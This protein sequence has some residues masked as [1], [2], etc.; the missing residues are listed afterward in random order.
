VTIRLHA[1]QIILLSSIMFVGLLLSAAWHGRPRQGRHNFLTDA[2]VFVLQL[3]ILY[4]GG[5]FG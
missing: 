4:W 1:P 3:L 5:F 2:A